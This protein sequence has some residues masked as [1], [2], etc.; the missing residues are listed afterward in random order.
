MA[1]ICLTVRYTNQAEIFYKK[2]VKVG[3]SDPIIST[4]TGYCST[5]K[6]Y[7]R[8][9]RLMTPERRYRR[10]RLAPRC[11]LVTS[12]LRKRFQG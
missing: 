5:D 9:N 7:A 2:F 10:G 12:W 8:D 6:R 4:W 3:H 11:R 1:K